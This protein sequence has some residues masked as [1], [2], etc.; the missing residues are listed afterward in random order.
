[1][2]YLVSILGWKRVQD[3]LN[4]CIRITEAPSLG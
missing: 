4:V 2:V 1:M 3:K